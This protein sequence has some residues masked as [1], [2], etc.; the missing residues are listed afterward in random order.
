MRVMNG[1]LFLAVLACGLQGVAAEPTAAAKRLKELDDK[2]AAAPDDPTLHFDKARCLMEL[3]RYDDGYG[4]A[5]KGRQLLGPATKSLRSTP[6]ESIVLETVRI[7]V[8][9]NL[10]PRERTPP[11]FGIARPLTF[12]VWT[13]GEAPELIDAIDFEIGYFEGKPRTAALGQQLGD[14]HANFG[15]FE[16]GS[17]Y[18]TI[19]TKALELI[20]QQA[21]RSR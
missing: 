20:R 5:C 14:A 16:P 8:Q 12:R 10:G 13:R 7:E 19:R 2:I 4:A 3:G 6:L 21:A 15:T 18:T 17:S 9:L 1:L 11:D